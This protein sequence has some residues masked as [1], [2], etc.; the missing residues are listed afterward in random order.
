MSAIWPAGPPKEV[1]PILA[2][3]RKASANVGW[4]AVPP[5][6]ADTAE[7]SFMAISYNEAFADDGQLCVSSLASRH[8]R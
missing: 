8:Q 3:T 4:G 6:E 1:M 7:T 2:H 5:V